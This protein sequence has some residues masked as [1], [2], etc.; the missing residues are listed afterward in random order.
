MITSRT[1]VK[2]LESATSELSKQLGRMPTVSEIAKDLGESEEAV[3]ESMEVGAAAHPM[4]LD[5]AVVGD[6][7]MNISQVIGQE[8]EA[9]DKIEYR[10]FLKRILGGLNETERWIIE[11]RYLKGR[12]QREVAQDI[13]VSQMYVSR[14]ERK[15]LSG[16]RKQV[17][18]G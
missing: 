10:D 8:E 6:Q 13:G 7:E 17:G 1:K 3:L 12:S 14:L 18:V 15:I 2:A 11:Q 16:I 4:S 5:V 9:Y